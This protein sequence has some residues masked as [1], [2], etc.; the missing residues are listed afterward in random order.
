[1]LNGGENFLENLTWPLV[2]VLC[3][4]IESFA[5]AGLPRGGA[6]KEETRLCAVGNE[7]TEVN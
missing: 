1:M 4:V 2:N 7:L 5:E 3:R 6:T